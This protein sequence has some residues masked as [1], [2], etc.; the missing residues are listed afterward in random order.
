[1]L[2]KQARRRVEY[3]AVNDI[4]EQCCL[5][6]YQQGPVL[7]HGHVPLQ[8]HEAGQEQRQQLWYA[9]MSLALI[10]MLLEAF[11]ANWTAVRRGARA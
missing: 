3:D 10:L 5:P 11:A 1:M 8:H 7:F 9:I 4:E 2:A 6:E